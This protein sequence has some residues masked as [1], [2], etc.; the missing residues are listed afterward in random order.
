MDTI[1]ARLD[2][3]ETLLELFALHVV[4]RVMDEGNITVHNFLEFA[5]PGSSRE[6]GSSLERDIL[7]LSDFDPVWNR[8]MKWVLPT[9][10]VTREI[11]DFLLGCS[12]VKGQCIS[13]YES[14]ATNRLPSCGNPCESF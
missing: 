4:K 1:E 9:V 13:L 3:L 12:N 10:I 5:K 2:V 8:R 6:I 14:R 7:I 11:P